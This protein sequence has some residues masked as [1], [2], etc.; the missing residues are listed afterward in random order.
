M[1]RRLPAGSRAAV[2][3]A[4]SRAAVADWVAAAVGWEAAVAGLAAVVVDSVAAVV[5]SSASP[6]K[7]LRRKLQRRQR[8]RH[9]THQLL[10]TPNPAR[11][12]I[13][14]QLLRRLWSTLPKNR[15][16]SG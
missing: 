13:A 16:T 2:L 9:S 1:R 7:T 12:Q 5:V 6:M 4:G 3:A 14:N 10:P 8:R 15:T 11:L